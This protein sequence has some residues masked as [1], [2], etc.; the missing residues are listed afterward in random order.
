MFEYHVHTYLNLSL[1]KQYHLIGQI[2][3]YNMVQRFP[4][5]Q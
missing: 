2:R 5:I 3:R 4:H 1:Q